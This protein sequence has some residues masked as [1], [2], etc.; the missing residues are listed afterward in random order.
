MT[1]SGCNFS[2]AGKSVLIYNEGGEAGNMTITFKECI[3]TASSK[4]AGKAA[5]EVDASLF[6]H[7][8][9]VNIDK[10]TAENIS[11]FGE[12]SKSGSSVWNNKKDPAKDKVT[13]TISVG[14]DIV[15]SKT[16]TA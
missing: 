12:G 2:C 5:V 10:S 15:L 3:M 1:F 9:T 6:K 4:V 11:G 16:K 8:C 13:L 7:S 14:G